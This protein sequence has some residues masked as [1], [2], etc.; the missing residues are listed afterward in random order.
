M[1]ITLQIFTR[2]NFG[3]IID[4]HSFFLPTTKTVSTVIYFLLPAL[5][6]HSKKYL[7]SA[8]C[9]NTRVQAWWGLALRECLA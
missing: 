2:E 6:I 9:A 7:S 8:Y 1:F 3:E 4:N 5:Y